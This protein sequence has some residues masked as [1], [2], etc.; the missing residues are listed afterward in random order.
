[1]ATAI[2]PNN[3]ALAAISNAARNGSADGTLMMLVTSG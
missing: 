1:M 3:V 2:V